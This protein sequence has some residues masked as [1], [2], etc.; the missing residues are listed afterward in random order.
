MTFL[1]LALRALDMD[2]LTKEQRRK[3]MQHIRSENTKSEVMLCKALWRKG[4]RYR[5]NYKELPGKPDIAITKHKIAV[6]VDGGFWHARGHEEH[7]GEQIKTNNAFWIKKLKRN[8]ERDKEVN[9]ALLEM[10]WLVLRYWD[11]DIKKN[12]DACVKDIIRYLPIIYSERHITH[13]RNNKHMDF[14]ED[15]FY[16]W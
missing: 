7:P 5:K 11:S 2:V 15:D 12:C 1:L 13:R 14:E 8:V 9:Q 3:N 16:R 4:I 10:G 6:F